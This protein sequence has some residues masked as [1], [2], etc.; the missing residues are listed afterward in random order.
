VISALARAVKCFPERPH[1][2]ISAV[3]IL[4]EDLACQPGDPRVSAICPA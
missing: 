4:Q 2:P 3:T 1:I